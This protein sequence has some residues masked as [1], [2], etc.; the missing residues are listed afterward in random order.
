MFSSDLP[1]DQRQGHNYFD[2]SKSSTYKPLQGYSWNI[3]YQDGS[4]ATGVV[5]TD[6]VVVGDTTVHNQ[7]VEL[8]T[9]VSSE[10]LSDSSDGLIG[11][12]FSSVN[13]G[14]SLSIT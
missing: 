10:F 13:T 4:G 12:A 6:T 5:G 2:P 11:L 8:A 9:Q 7:A 1:E 14:I 3:G